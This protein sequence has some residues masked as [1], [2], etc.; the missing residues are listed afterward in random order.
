MGLK[1]LQ[2]RYAAKSAML[3]KLQAT[4]GLVV[5]YTPLEAEMVNRLDDELGNLF[6]D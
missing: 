2:S 4:N 1:P 5:E 6:A 3:R